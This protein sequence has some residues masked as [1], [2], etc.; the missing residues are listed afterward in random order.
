MKIGQYLARS[1]AQRG[2]T[3]TPRFVGVPM[4]A[5]RFPVEGRVGGDQGVHPMVPQD[6][7]ERRNRLRIEVG[8]QFDRKRTARLVT[9]FEPAA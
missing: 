2:A 6:V 1:F 5:D 8:R 9:V 7:G 4:S 3:E